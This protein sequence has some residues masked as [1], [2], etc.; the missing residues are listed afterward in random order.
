MAIVKKLID[1]LQGEVHVE[2]EYG[3]GSTFTVYFPYQLERV[4][5]SAS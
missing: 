1:L 2:S 5:E 4:K 3:K